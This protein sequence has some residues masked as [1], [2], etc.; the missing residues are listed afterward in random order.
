[1]C[2]DYFPI[3][4]KTVTEMEYNEA[5]EYLNGFT[6][7]GVPIKNLSRFRG[8]M[9]TLDNI[10]DKLKYIHVAGTN[11]KGSVCEYTALAL[12]YSGYKAGKFTS[13]YINR[14]EERIQINGAPISEGDLAFYIS[15][16]REA[17][18]KTGCT[19]YS[20]FEILNA[21]AF[22]YFYDK[23]CGIT[24]LETGIGGLLDCSNII[25]PVLSIITTVD[26]DHCAILGDTPEK[27]AR[28]KAGIIKPKRPVILS[29]FQYDEVIRIV[30]EKAAETGS[31]LIIPAS[32]DL[33]LI[34]ADLNGTEFLYKNKRFAVGMCGGH[35]MINASAAV[36][37]MRELE[38]GEE[39]IEAAL[40]NAAVPARMEKMGGFIIDGAHNVSG[41]KAA[42]ELI[43][44]SNGKKT[45]IVG[46]LK[47]KDYKGAL[48]VLLPV[49]DRVIAVDF[50]S[51]D[52]VKSEEISALAKSV[53]CETV[54]A[55]NGDDA[56]RKA[57]ETEA[58]LRM[59]CGSL[60]LCGMMRGKLTKNEETTQG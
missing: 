24:V 25:D 5:I 36:E 11:G 8:L 41:A 23:K 57:C 19:D 3:K 20:Q 2:F 15:K 13:P 48:A 7:S 58:D 30:R 40:K 18:D 50:F 27:I 42:A 16:V 52:A 43:G 46:M 10:Q 34:K 17:A 9:A 26:L 21:A 44:G 1:M 38:I 22:L 53:G 29:P 60:Y 51:P 49:F 14:V 39:H 54:T 45:L 55:D 12:E 32:D 35:Q 6:K 37:A 31:K 28:H 4:E 47:S 33:K 56:L 59:I